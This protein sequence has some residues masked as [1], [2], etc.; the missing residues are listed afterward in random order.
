MILQL[1]LMFTVCGLFL[2]EAEAALVCG[3]NDS[4]PVVEMSYCGAF[5]ICNFFNTFILASW[6]RNSVSTSNTF[7]IAA[8]C[9][10]VLLV[11]YG[12]SGIMMYRVWKGFVKSGASQNPTPNLQP[13]HPGS[14]HPGI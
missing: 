14:M 6:Q 8:L 13:G 7:T 3:G 12:I 10:F 5:A 11:F 4:W 1:V 2:Y 9:T